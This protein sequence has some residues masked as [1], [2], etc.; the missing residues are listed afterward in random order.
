M[1]A[2][3]STVR[4]TYTAFLEPPLRPGAASLYCLVAAI[5][6]SA[7]IAPELVYPPDRQLL[8][9]R[10]R[11]TAGATTTPRATREEGDGTPRPSTILPC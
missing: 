1:R 11:G 9:H 6:V 4:S 10:N 3:V 7:Q 2:Y 8:P 5:R